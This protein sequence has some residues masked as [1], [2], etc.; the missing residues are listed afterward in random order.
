MI[1]GSFKD[2]VAPV[3]PAVVRFREAIL[4]FSVRLP[5]LEGLLELNCHLT[6]L[7]VPGSEEQFKK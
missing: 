6:F 3:P 7:N 1:I 5:W 2:C 4:G